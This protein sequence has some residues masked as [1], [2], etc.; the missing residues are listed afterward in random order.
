MLYYHLVV[1]SCYFEVSK[2][3]DGFKIKY[4]NEAYEVNGLLIHMKQYQ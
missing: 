3:E 4:S 2:S 1:I